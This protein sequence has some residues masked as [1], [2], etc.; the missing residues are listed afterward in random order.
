MTLRN[1]HLIAYATSMVALILCQLLFYTQPF[2][3][4]SDFHT[5]VYY[6]LI[7]QI[8]CMGAIPFLTL[9]A[10]NRGKVLP[11]LKLMRYKPPRDK[12]SCFLLAVGLMLLITPFTMTFN[13]LTNLFFSIVGYKRSYPV[14][15]IY[16]GAGDFFLMIFLTAL[17]PAIFEEFTHRGLLLSGLENRGSE[18]SAVVVSAMMFGLMHENPAQLFYAFFGGLVFGVAVIK[19]DSIIPAMCAHFANNAVSVILDFSVQRQNPFGVWYSKFFG[20]G[21]VLSVAITVAVLGFSVYGVVKLLQYISRK[22][23]KPIS[24]RKLFGV[25]T[26]DSFK[27]DGRATL[28]DNAFLIAVIV[29][30]G[31]LSLS[32]LAWGIGR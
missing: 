17:L 20:A 23:P 29:S 18:L 22:A 32:L 7:S 10:L 14:G 25:V 19:T 12:R 24:E 27:P 31:L 30:E 9:L 2:Q 4:L 11:E 1:K 21:D 28:K 13:A 5:D 16:L 8:I 26:L 3:R 6:T 15:M